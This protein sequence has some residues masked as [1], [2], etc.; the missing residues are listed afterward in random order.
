MWLDVCG[1]RWDKCNE[2]LVVLEGTSV[3]RSLWC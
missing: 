3:A 1:V 2:M